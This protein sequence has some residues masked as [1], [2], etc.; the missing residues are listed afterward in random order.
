MSTGNITICF[1]IW[2][3]LQTMSTGKITTRF[4]LQCAASL[5]ISAELGWTFVSALGALGGW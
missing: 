4:L 5:L 1:L 2:E 3:A